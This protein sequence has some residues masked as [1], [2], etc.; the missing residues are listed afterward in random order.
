MKRHAW[1]LSLTLLL[2]LPAAAQV[3]RGYASINL[4][5]RAGPDI[6]YPTVDV[7]PYGAPLYVH[8]CTVDWSWCD[9]SVYDER[10]WV[11]G[12]Y[13]DYPYRDRWVSVYNYGGLIGVPV[14]RFVIGD[15]W[16]DH[17][18]HRHF[19]R[20]RDYWYHQ[21]FAYHRVPRYH[22]ERRRLADAFRYDQDR[23]H[24]RD[25]VRRSWRDGDRRDHD[26]RYRQDRDRR[27]H[28]R[29]RRDPRM[30]QSRDNHADRV[31]RNRMIVRDRYRGDRHEGHKRRLA[32][33]VARN[34]LHRPQ[35]RSY[36]TQRSEH[37]Q[38]LGSFRPRPDR[39]GLASVHPSRHR[40]HAPVRHGSRSQ[41]H[42]GNSHRARPPVHRGHRNGDGKHRRHHR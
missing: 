20:D 21:R 11:A 3:T 9:V 36:T 8:G 17:Y 2:A 38:R 19:Y 7:L 35:G 6:G 23:R 5:L 33:T 16:H 15:Y 14:I 42:Q 40:G 32:P 29:N 30:H 13:I 18:R 25:R 31:Q 12:D 26:R 1:L 37:R 24:D 28:D 4:N 39:D 41:G 27:D 10:G 22:H 34:A